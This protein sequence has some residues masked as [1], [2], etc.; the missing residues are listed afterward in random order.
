MASSPAPFTGVTRDP[1]TGKPYPRDLIGY[2]QNP[3]HPHWPGEARIAVQFVVNYEEGGENSILH[4]DNAS[5]AFLSEIIGAQPWPRQR[6]M[7]MESIYEYGARAGIWR[8]LRLFTERSMPVTVYGVATALAR[9]P[10][11]VAAMQEAGWELASHGYKWLEYKDFTREDEREHILEAVRLHTQVTGERPLGFYQG[12]SAEHTVPL[13]ME[14][15]GFLYA[16]DSYAD[17]LPYW[18]FGPKGP[19]LVVP[20]TLDANDMRFSVA[21]GFGSGTEFYDYLKD[22][23]D[24]LYAEGERAPKMLSIGLH[25]RL[26]GRPG[27]AAA[28]ARFLDYV[29]GHEKVW[30]AR[31]VDIARHWIAHHPPAGGYRPT[32]MPRGLFVERFGGVYEHSPWIAE[33]AY[34]RGLTASEDTAEGLNAAF[35]AVLREAPVE[36][37]MAVIHAHPDLA[38][39]LAQAR[40]LTADSTAEQAS[41]GLDRLT[42]EEKARFTALNDAYTAKFGFVFIMAIRGRAKA[43]ILDAFERRLRNDPEAEVAEALSQI[44]RIAL[45]RLAQMLPEA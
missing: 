16:A 1:V 4:G 27:R 19:Q 36:R 41:A 44:E 21:A 37:Q 42:A 11:A 29:A 22:S 6:H 12:R 15:G 18:I 24:C 32:Y 38:G 10:D 25:P 34:D 30:V 5:E 28:L 2:G 7:N 35:A 17:D 14:E 40:L 9:N 31:R 3:P 26:A 43:E 23:F 20:Y 13:V 39:K 8:L 45:L 33:T